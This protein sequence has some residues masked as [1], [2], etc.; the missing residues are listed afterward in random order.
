M[1]HTAVQSQILGIASHSTQSPSIVLGIKK[2][3]HKGLNGEGLE[4][5]VKSSTILFLK[6]ANGP[7]NHPR[8]LEQEAEINVQCFSVNLYDV[9]I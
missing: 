1:R 5:K 8:T 3:K 2:T 7:W 6:A 9:F 4:K